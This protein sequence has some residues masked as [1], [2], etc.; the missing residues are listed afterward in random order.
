MSFLSL[1]LSQLPPQAALVRVSSDR[2][3]RSF[4]LSLSFYSFSFSSSVLDTPKSRSQTSKH[5]SNRQRRASKRSPSSSRRRVA[6][7]SLLA[8][9]SSSVAD[10]FVSQTVFFHFQYPT[11]TFTGV[12]SFYHHH[13]S[14]T[15][16]SAPA[17]R[18]ANQRTAEE[19]DSLVKLLASRSASLDSVC[20]VLSKQVRS[21]S[22]LLSHPLLSPLSRLPPAL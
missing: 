7:L 1:T 3:H 15:F 18:R 12:A 8:S 6:S 2:Y 14:S 10:A 11:R 22:L 19:N 17:I 16:S 13:R 9:L 21:I 20:Q 4:A 5:S